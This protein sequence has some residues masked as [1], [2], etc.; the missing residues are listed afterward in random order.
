MSEKSIYSQISHGQGS[1]I[2]KAICDAVGEAGGNANCIL[3]L[4]KEGGKLILG[5]TASVIAGHWN[6]REIKA[7]NKTFLMVS[8]E[9]GTMCEEAEKKIISL[10]FLPVA[11]HHCYHC[12]MIHFPDDL[13]G[14]D[15]VFL[16]KE[17]DE[18]G[19]VRVK[20]HVDIGTSREYGC[21]GFWDAGWQI[22]TWFLGVKSA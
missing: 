9:G 12:L 4:I 6:V 18:E 21:R 16:A 8:K 17:I 7:G 11:A 20:C 5:E 2:L 10:G 14:A 3:R 19:K 15:V 22:G 13:R 1:E